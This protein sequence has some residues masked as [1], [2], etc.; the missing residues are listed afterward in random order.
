MTTNAIS[1]FQSAAISHGISIGTI[2]GA[3]YRIVALTG[4]KAEKLELNEEQIFRI[5]EL[6]ER[7]L[8]TAAGKDGKSLENV[9]CITDEGIHFADNS[10]VEP[11]TYLTNALTEEQEKTR[12]DS[13][14]IS[15]YYKNLLVYDAVEDG[16]EAEMG[17]AELNTL[18]LG[19][20]TI[21]F[22]WESIKQTLFPE[23][24][25][26]SQR[27]SSLL[28]RRSFS[29][30]SSLSTSSRSS[31]QPSTASTHS[32]SGD[33]VVKRSK[34]KATPPAQSP[35]IQQTT[36]NKTPPS[37]L[38]SPQH[39]AS[40]VHTPHKENQEEVQSHSPES[41]PPLSAV[42]SEHNLAA[43]L[44]GEFAI[45]RMTAQSPKNIQ[46]VVNSALSQPTSPQQDNSSVND[47]AKEAEK[48]RI[49][50]AE[51]QLDRQSKLAN[52]ETQDRLTQ[53][54]E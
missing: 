12:N 52:Q 33:L 8:L 26:Q 48:A 24:S 13:N 39:S 17:Y 16:S 31:S 45:V 28:S 11:S 37:A 7:I 6:A 19:A 53:Y 30:L 25:Y 1:Q 18:L 36:Q 54:D 4:D 15:A 2:G 38:V 44:L 43:T 29:P 49:K 21:H 23:E 42:S 35:P 32:N 20:H 10:I 47:E 14:R 46:P 27:G 9:T 51:D 5:R 22:H 3:E 40:T 41:T 50:L 34:R